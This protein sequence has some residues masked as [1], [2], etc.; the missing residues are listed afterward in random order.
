MATAAAAVYR[1]ASLASL[2]Q[3]LLHQLAA[4]NAEVG[5]EKLCLVSSQTARTTMAAAAMAP[6]PG[7][8]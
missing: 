4:V 3:P 2:P 7:F 6:P 8:L 5:D 1:I